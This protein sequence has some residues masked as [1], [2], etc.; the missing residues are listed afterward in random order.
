ML[1]PSE[2]RHHRYA[3]KLR[4]LMFASLTVLRQMPHHF[5]IFPSA[6]RPT[7]GLFVKFV[8]VFLIGRKADNSL[9][10]IFLRQR[11]HRP[12]G[13]TYMDNYFNF[14]LKPPIQHSTF[15]ISST[16]TKPRRGSSPSISFP[17]YSL[18]MS[19][20]LACVSTGYTPDTLSCQTVCSVR[21][22]RGR[23]G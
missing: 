18:A 15:V 2:G 22:P 1:G 4:L 20:P 7:L 10:P 16:S 17:L 8:F 12:Q 19:C 11:T 6:V 9:I 14:F 21:S 3:T 13:R 5:T 23:S